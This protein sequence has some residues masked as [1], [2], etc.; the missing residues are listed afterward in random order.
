MKQVIGSEGPGRIGFEVFKVQSA[1][2]VIIQVTVE[3]FGFNMIFKVHGKWNHTILN[4]LWGYKWLSS[5]DIFAFH[6]FDSLSHPLRYYVTL[7]RSIIRTHILWKK[8][9]TVGAFSFLRKKRLYIYLPHLNLLND[10]I[11]WCY[12]FYIIYIVINTLP[13]TLFSSYI[14]LH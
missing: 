10:S 3:N 6:L 11:I 14:F 8:K 7:V 13:H 4:I 2:W 12:G 5:P 1:W 9:K